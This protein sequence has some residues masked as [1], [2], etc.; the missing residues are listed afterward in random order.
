MTASTRSSFAL[1]PSCVDRSSICRMLA[2]AL[3]LPA[4]YCSDLPY[5]EE[6]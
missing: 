5:G 4:A 2:A 3:G 1:L 6:W